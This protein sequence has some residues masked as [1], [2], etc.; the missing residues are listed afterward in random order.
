M[1]GGRDFALSQFNRA[2]QSERE[3]GSSF[4]PYVYTT[5]VEAGA[6][7]SDII[8]DGPVSFYTPNGPYTPHNYEGDYK[9]AM[10][11]LNAFAES[12][13]IPALKLADKVGIRK[14]IETAHRFGVTS[15]MPAYLPIAI[16]AADI[17]LYEQVQSFSVFPNDGIR[18]QPHYIRRV[19]Q[20][21]GMSLD[22][23]PAQVAQV[24]S[25]DTAR[26]MMEFLEAVTRM[27]T[28]AAAAQL[29]HP[30]GGKTGTTND[31]TDAWFI[32]FSPS[33]TCGTWIGFDNRQS[34]GE[35][36]TGAKAALP[37][38][39]DFMRAAIA[40][41]PDEKFPEGNAPRKQIQTSPVAEGEVSTEAKEPP[42][43]DPDPEPPGSPLPV[44]PH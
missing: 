16:G 35:K 31:Y 24:I 37:M 15:N 19:V 36:E 22:Q 30:F 21:S 12:R 2:T 8:V 3:V 41:K 13:N 25:V 43:D 20:A 26:T 9:G 1:V 18:I 32:G 11:L 17:S 42:P 14:V 29:K 7:P 4:K 33:V 44:V 27:G 28:G 5:A 34:L 6:Q 39:M 38:W 40:G 23:S 10:T